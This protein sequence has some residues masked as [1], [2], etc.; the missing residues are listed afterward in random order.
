MAENAA[1]LMVVCRFP[2]CELQCP[3]HHRRIPD[4]KQHEQHHKIPSSPNM[5]PQTQRQTT[6]SRSFISLLSISSSDTKHTRHETSSS[7]GGSSAA[8]AVEIAS[9]GCPCQVQQRCCFMWGLVLSA[10]THRIRKIAS[11]SCRNLPFARNFAARTKVSQFHLQNHSDSLANCIATLNS[12]I[13]LRC[14]G[15]QNLLTNL[16]GG[17]E[18]AFTFAAVSLRPRCAHVWFHRRFVVL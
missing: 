16:R 14:G 15:H 17:P 3:K 7:L 4:M 8:T 6:A 18:F 13:C 10:P 5:K 9:S 11:K 12:H 2:N 1:K